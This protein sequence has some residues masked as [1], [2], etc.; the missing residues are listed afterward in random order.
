VLVL[1]GAA[2]AVW[3]YDSSLFTALLPAPAAEAPAA[4]VP[5]VAPAG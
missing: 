3:W 5:E 4:P 2:A 1:V